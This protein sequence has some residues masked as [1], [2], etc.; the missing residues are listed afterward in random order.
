MSYLRLCGQ[1][2]NVYQS[3]EGANK[4]TGETYGGTHHVQ[5]LCED[6]MR[7]GEMKLAMFTLRTDHPELFKGQ[8]GKILNVPVGAWVK[9]NE[10]AFFL[11][12]GLKPTEALNG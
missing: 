3:P 7:N 10:V 9:G 4:E 1:V 6:V 8:V 11:P 12:K 2:S 5:M